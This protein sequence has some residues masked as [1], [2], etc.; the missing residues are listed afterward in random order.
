MYISTSRSAWEKSRVT[1]I[2]AGES[3]LAVHDPV[4]RRVL[5]QLRVPDRE[6]RH[7]DVLV[8]RLGIE[9]GRVGEALVSS[10]R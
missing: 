2:E 8:D 4:R 1:R 7:L 5:R 6:M 9:A 3:S 10:K